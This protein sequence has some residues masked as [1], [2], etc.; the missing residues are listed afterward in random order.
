MIVRKGH[1]LMS[2]KRKGRTWNG[3]ISEWVREWFF[4]GWLDDDV[5][6]SI[7][8]SDLLSLQAAV[9]DVV[10]F[11]FCF[12]FFRVSA[13]IEAPELQYAEVKRDGSLSQNLK[14]CNNGS[15]QRGNRSH[16][17]KLK[18][19]TRLWWS[20]VPKGF[21]VHVPCQFSGCAIWESTENPSL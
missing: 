12:F 9:A 13:A 8:S 4:V 6:I 17:K 5:L 7:I 2:S 15:L 10:F 18:A 3:K 20:P 1:V 14:T 19:G 16:P 21:F 11:M